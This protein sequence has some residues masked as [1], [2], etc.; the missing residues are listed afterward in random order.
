[1]GLILAPQASTRRSPLSS[2]PWSSSTSAIDEASICSALQACLGRD[3]LERLNWRAR[4][5]ATRR[6]VSGP[7]SALLIKSCSAADAASRRGPPPVTSDTR[8]RRAPIFVENQPLVAHAVVR[9]VVDVSDRRGPAAPWPRALAR[10]RSRAPLRRGRRPPSAR[11]GR[12]AR[13]P[14]PPGSELCVGTRRPGRGLAA[15]FSSPAA[16]TASSAPATTSSAGRSLGGLRIPASA[17]GGGSRLLRAPSRTPLP[18]PWRL[19]FFHVPDQAEAIGGRP[20]WRVASPRDG[21]F[22]GFL[23]VLDELLLLRDGGRLHRG[24]R[25]AGR[26]QGRPGAPPGAGE[27]AVS[28][29]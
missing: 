23:R 7:A 21:L 9:V 19:G 3:H 26:L 28:T 24:E 20:P 11:F 17:P 29:I 25:E 16:A 10:Q 6:H 12:T 8:E 2:L 15:R 5:R 4:R 18:R 22:Y 1:M 13:S 14:R 27:D